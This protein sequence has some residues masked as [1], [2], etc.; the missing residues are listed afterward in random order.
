MLASDDPFLPFWAIW[1]YFQWFQLTVRFREGHLHCKVVVSNIFYFHPYLVKIPILTSTVDGRNPAPPA[2]YQLVSR[3]SSINDIFQM[4]CSHQLDWIIVI[5][6]SSTK[7]RNTRVPTEA[8]YQLLGKVFKQ[9]SWRQIPILEQWKKIGYF[10]DYT[11]SSCLGWYRV[12]NTPLK[13]YWN[14]TRVLFVA[15]MFCFSCVFS[16]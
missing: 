2:M 13:R 3:I 1:A 9:K 8:E 12:Y 16:D 6:P 10:G 4:G 11:T 14:V 15:Y 7:P 5:G